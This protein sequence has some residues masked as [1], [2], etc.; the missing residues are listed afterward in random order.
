MALARVADRIPA[1]Q[2]KDHFSGHADAY[3]RARPTY[4]AALYDFLHECS[5][6]H[7]LAWDCATGNGQAARMLGARFKNVIATDASATQ[8][9][10]AEPCS[11]VEFRVAPAE[12]SG[13]PA[14][15]IDLVTVAQALHWFD[16]ERFFDECARVLKPGGVL[17]VWCYGTCMI[18]P[19]CDRIVHG[20]YERLSPWWPPERRIVERGYSDIDLPFEAFP[21]PRFEMTVD[22]S[23]ADMLDY[24]ATWSASQHCLRD[25]G[26]DPVAAIRDELHAA[27]GEAR[28]A[29]HWP[30]YL[31][32]ARNP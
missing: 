21:C 8:V 4:P 1:S 2:F 29:V 22:W 10:A 25:T 5:A 28:R 17:A 3:A 6:D 32:A 20:L 27:W 19:A 14:A 13:L 23:A 11:N 12:A 26:D 30:L 15:S 18:E 31:K 7:S 24:I 9:A 16:I